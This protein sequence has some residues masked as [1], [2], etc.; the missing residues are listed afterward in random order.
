M[1]FIRW[2]LIF[3][4]FGENLVSSH[5]V[6]GDG[7]VLLQEKLY[8]VMAKSTGIMVDTKFVCIFWMFVY[9]KVKVETGSQQTPLSGQ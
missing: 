4:K 7:M 3:N 1:Q 2:W 6:G 8:T 9:T 5:F